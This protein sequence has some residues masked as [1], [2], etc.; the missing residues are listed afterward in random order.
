MQSVASTRLSS[1]WS[2]HGLRDDG[3]C[4]IRRRTPTCLEARLENRSATCIQAK[5]VG[6]S[7][8]MSRVVHSPSVLWRNRQIEARIVLRPKPR[9]YHSDFK[10]KSP[11]RSCRFWG[12]NQK[13]EPLILRSN[14]KKPSSPVLRSNREKIVVTGFEVNPEK[15]VPVVLRPSH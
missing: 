7:Q 5:Q 8:H 4:T 6:R 14:R 3:T 15:I 9:N 11:N 12:P 1:T 10:A 2:S 13:P